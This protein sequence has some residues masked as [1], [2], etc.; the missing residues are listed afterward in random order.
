MKKLNHRLRV[1][2]N[3]L[4][5][6][7]VAE[8]LLSKGAEVNARTE[9]CIDL[10]E[11]A[12]LMFPEWQERRADVIVRFEIKEKIEPPSE[13]ATPLD[14]AYR[15]NCKQLITLLEKNGGKRGKELK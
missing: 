10:S 11:V 4:T 1:C 8:L 2:P 13:E 7:N 15:I 9:K 12:E 5:T 6:Y 14:L 3:Y